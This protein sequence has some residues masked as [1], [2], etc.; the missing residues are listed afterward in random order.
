M[1]FG[2]GLRSPTGEMDDRLVSAIGGHRR[3]QMTSNMTTTVTATTTASCCIALL[4]TL[5]LSGPR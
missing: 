4:V 3:R 1:R 5:S 2:T